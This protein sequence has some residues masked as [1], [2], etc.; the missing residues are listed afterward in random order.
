MYHKLYDFFVTQNAQTAIP[1]GT[2]LAILVSTIVYILMAIVA[3]TCAVRDAT[4]VIVKAAGSAVLAPNI[5][6]AY[7]IVGGLLY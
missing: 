5:T 4:G 7:V 6:G 2:L 3:G 1:K